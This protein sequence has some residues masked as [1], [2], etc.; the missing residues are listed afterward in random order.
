MTTEDF[1][2]RPGRPVYFVG[3][4]SAEEKNICQDFRFPRDD[5][6]MAK[7]L[8]NL[9]AECALAGVALVPSCDERGRTTFI[10]SHGAL[11]EELPDLAAV[12]TWLERFTGSG[13]AG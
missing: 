1:E 4:S 10:A 2:S 8:E 3:C 6:S 7:Q 11:T 13:H 9:R 5:S 12:Q